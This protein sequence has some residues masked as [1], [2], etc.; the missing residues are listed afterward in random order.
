MTMRRST[1][2]SAGAAA[3]ATV[4][5]AACGGGGDAGGDGPLS[6]EV[7]QGYAADGAAMPL[8]AASGLDSADVALEAAVATSA[9]AG[10]P[11]V[12]PLQ[13]QA[14]AEASASATCEGG[15]TIRWT[16]T[17]PSATTIGN[18][19][20]DAGEAYAVTYTNCVVDGSMLDGGL[21]VTVGTDRSATRLTL[22]KAANALRTT[23]PRGSFIVNGALTTVR[24]FEDLGAAGSRHTVHHTSSGVSLNSAIGGRTASYNLNSWDW[25]VVRTYSALPA[26]TSRTHQGTLSMAAS[27]ARRPNATLVVSTQ[28]ALTL[29]DDGWASAGSFSVVTSQ[30]KITGVHGGGSITLTLDVGN[31]GTIE[32]TWTLTRTNFTAEAG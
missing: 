25:T 29:G 14:L 17:A 15:G 5:L 31:D 3:A 32:R 22:T 30:Q 2:R 23:T 19:R 6:S 26:L 13:A 16:V 9:A 11:P 18:G 21:S 12:R 1:R 28:G 24:D 27:T 4:L 8:T 10:A 7:A 20:L